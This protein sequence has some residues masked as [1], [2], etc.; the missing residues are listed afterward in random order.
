MQEHAIPTSQSRASRRRVMKFGSAPCGAGKTFSLVRKACEMVSEGKNVLLVQPTLNL[1]DKTKTEELDRLPNAPVVKIFHTGTVGAKVAHQLAEYLASP[2]DCPQIVMATHQVLNHLPFV[3][4]GKDWHLLIDEAPQVHVEQSHVVPNTHPLLTNLIQVDQH[5]GVYGQVAVANIEELMLLARNPGEDELLEKFRETASIL[6]NPHW[7]SY[8]NLEQ[9]HRLLA[10]EQ[11]LLTIH[12]VL[13]PSI[14]DKFASIFIAAAN[15]RDTGIFHL[16]DKYQ[17]RWVADEAFNQGLRFQ[18]HQNGPLTTIH[19]ALA[20]NWSRNLLEKITD[21]I[22]NLDR[23]RDAA[24]KVIGSQRFLWQANKVVPDT[25]F[26]G[27]DRLPHN[28][29]GLNGYSEVNNIVF[30]SA[31]NPSPAHCRFLNAQGLSSEEIERQVYCGIGYQAIMRTSLRVAANSDRKNIIVPDERLAQYLCE[32]LPG[33]QVR[34]LDSGIA[35]ETSSGGR[36]RI[37][38]TNTDK[39]RRRRA[40]EKEKRIELLN[41]VFCSKPSRPDAEAFYSPDSGP[42]MPDSEASVAIHGSLVVEDGYFAALFSH[43]KSATPEGYLFCADQ[44][45]F[46]RAMAA[47]HARTYDSKD[48]IPLFSP[49]IFDPNREATDSAGKPT[50]RGVGNIVSLINIVLDFENGELRPDDVP[51]L[52]PDLQMIV[53]NS[54]RHANGA[55]RFRVIILTSKRTGPQAYEALFDAVANKL[56]DAGYTRSPRRGSQSKKS[57]LDHSK[58]SAASLFYLPSQAQEGRDSFFAFYGDDGRRPLDPETWL[59]NAPFGV[60]AAEGECAASGPDQGTIDP[61]GVDAAIQ[62]WRIAGPGEGNDRFF[63]LAV[64]LKKLGMQSQELKAVL[65][66]E[67]SAGRS[68]SERAAQIPAIMRSLFNRRARR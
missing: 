48:S 26:V 67:A 38:A 61:A 63:S 47:L 52:F 50:R 30:L 4:T 54:F 9:Y 35:E 39:F 66:A 56:R 13:R 53:T 27:G 1:I 43:L 58:R 2:E 42:G 55:P 17:V 51:T 65:V 6:V 41:Q 24:K 28:S 45:T 33:A 49:A 60:P 5:D 32:R 57:G 12:S 18:E 19:F 20:K 59:A 22:S 15:F 44:E 7:R 3:T 31:L 10:C 36:P 8:V 68:P 64:A 23:M 37:H 29:L 11:R 46:V 25:F 34:K 21:G 16:W 14:V 40:Q 62:R